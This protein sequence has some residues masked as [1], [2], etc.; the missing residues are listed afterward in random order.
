MVGHFASFNAFLHMGGY[1]KYVWPAYL[2]VIFTLSINGLIAL[3][4]LQRSLQCLPR[5][6]AEDSYA[7]EA[8]T[9]NL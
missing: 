9:T 7:S 5:R 6:G 8:K 1:A 4:R 2:I 3:W